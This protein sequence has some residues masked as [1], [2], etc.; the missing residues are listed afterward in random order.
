MCGSCK[1]LEQFKLTDLVDKCKECC[2]SDTD[3]DSEKMVKTTLKPV[4]DN[5]YWTHITLPF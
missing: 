2:Q 1:E 4:I 5:L 3:G